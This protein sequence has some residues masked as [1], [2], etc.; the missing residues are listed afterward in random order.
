MSSLYSESSIK[1]DVDLHELRNSVVVNSGNPS[2]KGLVI[3]YNFPPFADASS[4]TVAKRVRQFQFPVDVISQ[5]LSSIRNEDPDLSCLLGELVQKSFVVRSKVSFG[6]WPEI[7]E[8]ILRGYVQVKGRLLDGH[9]DFIY[10]RA[11]FP[12]S[13][14]LAAYIKALHP[15]IRWISEFSDPVQHDVLGNPRKSSA[16]PRDIVVNRIFEVLPNQ[17]LDE[18]SPNP[19]VMLLCEAVGIFGADQTIYTNESQCFEMLRRYSTYEGHKESQAFI[20]PHPTLPREFYEGPTNGDYPKQNDQIN[21]GYFGEFYPN[22]GV[23]ELAFCI[24]QLE[25]AARNKIRLWVFTSDVEKARNSLAELRDVS[26]LRIQKALPLFEFL[27]VSD[28]MDWL[29]VCDVAPGINYDQNPY[30]PSKVSDYLGATARIIASIWPKSPLSKID[31]PRIAK[32]MIGD[33]KAL[34]KFLSDLTQSDI[35]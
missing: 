12:A 35:S 24:A 28:R 3:A 18:I 23:G 30:L 16:I 13:H 20:S 26:F 31:S 17:L 6:G 15:E 11:M 29:Y 21:I 25:E 32:F 2:P 10:S 22:R 19:S 14:F 8:F 7:R 1:V 9:Y 5:D 34:F 33:R 4:V 27:R